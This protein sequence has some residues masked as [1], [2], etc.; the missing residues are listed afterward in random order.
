M[1]NKGTLAIHGGED[2]R[3]HPESLPHAHAVLPGTEQH[4]DPWEDDPD[5][6]EM[7]VAKGIVFGL[8][9]SLVLWALATVIVVLMRAQ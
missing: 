5:D 8:L 9:C 2:V 1:Q 3:P 4:L 7:S 6:D